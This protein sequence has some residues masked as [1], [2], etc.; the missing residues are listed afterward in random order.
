MAEIDQRSKYLK[1]HASP[2]AIHER[3]LRVQ[4]RRDMEA[5]HGKAALAGKDVHHKRSVANGGSNSPSNLSISTRVPAPALRLTIRHFSSASAA[6]IA[7]AARRPANRPS[8]M[9]CTNPCIRCQ[10]FT[11]ARP[12][13]S[14]WAL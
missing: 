4:A 1:Y 13:R 11:S 8:S 5:T 6:L 7:S 9:R 12:G 2:K 14:R 10:P 3:A